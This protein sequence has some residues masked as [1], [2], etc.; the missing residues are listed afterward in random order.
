MLAVGWVNTQIVYDGIVQ[1]LAVALIAV[2]VVLVYRATRIINFAVGNMGVI[3]AALLSLLVV[4]YDVPFWVAL[5]IALL[6]GL[7]FGAVI[8][9]TV[10]RRLRNAPRVVVLVSTIGIAGLAQVIAFKIPQPSDVSAHYPATFGS[11]AWTIG[12]VSVRG[13]DLG[14]LILVPIA[15]VALIWFLDHTT[16]GKTVKAAASNP[17]LARLSSISPK[18]VSTMVWALAAVLST[19][20]IVLFAGE[21][22]TAAGL[23]NLG[24]ET[25]SYALAAAVIAGLR[26]FRIAVIA[27][28]VIGVGQSVLTYNFLATPGITDLLLLIAVFVAVFFAKREGGEESG[29]FAFSPRTRPIPERLRSIW[30]ARNI[31]KGGILLLGA[32]AVILPLV[33]TEP[34]KQQLYTAVL[35][36]AICASSLTVLTGWLGQLSLG[37][38]AFAGLAALFAARLVTD[39]VPFWVAIATT[40]AASGLLALGVGIGSLRVRGLYLAVVTF[41]LALTAQQY[42]YYLPF[43]SGESPDGQNVPFVPGRLFSLNFPGQR[44]YYYVVLF[45]L[46]L[47]V[48]LLSRLRDSGTGRTIKALRDNEV[49][50][51]AYGVRP[52]RLKLKAFALSGA[53][54][55]LGGALLAGAYANVAFTQ[56]FFLV[57]DSLNL[58]AMVVIG[59]MGSVSGAII[60][61]VVVIGIPALAPN[62]ALVGLLSSSLGLLIVLMYFPRGLNQ[63]TSGLRDAILDWADRRVGDRPA[64]ARPTAAGVVSRHRETTTLADS[65][66]VLDVTDLS[67][68]FGGLVAVDRVSL[69]V[70][71]G[72]IVGLIGANGAGKST[73]MNAVGGFV[74]SAGSVRLLG[75]DVADKPP[76]Y[77]ASLGLGRTFQ[78]ATLFPE[79]TVNETLLVATEARANAGMLTSALGLPKT[80]RRSRATRAEVSELVSFLGLDRY[81]ETYISDLS[82]GTRR[83]VELGGL[84][85]LDAKVLCLDE[86]TAGL[87]QRETEAFGPLI[88]AIQ[89]ELSASVLLIE[90]DMPLIMGISERVYCLETGRIIAE[91]T[92]TDMRE[93][94]RVIASYLGTDERAIVRSGDAKTA[95]R[96]T[97]AADGEDRESAPLTR[98]PGVAPHAPAG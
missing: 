28:L 27:S 6:A 23:S 73:L 75:E 4:Q 98:S 8:E 52:A 54:A 91:G 17:W 43:F 92:P 44:N 2:G 63:L 55:G 36:F 79:L 1:G 94:P 77:R 96:D 12:S 26:S 31:D 67:V 5:A 86:P 56:D 74:P 39:G 76:G 90:H 19:L 16:I 51:T 47:V 18:L 41:V 88:C 21:T 97:A 58:V 53:L 30:W 66:P 14:I 89:K 93:D 48:A 59:G 60:G 13:A 34:S 37:Q 81:R 24:P 70:D 15:V 20:S 32:V 61:A 65:G 7:V 35:G 40:V 33:Q 84:L 95:P 45:V 62:N 29:V 68:R 49:A 80:R 64:P 72:E 3:G 85:A 83:I 87:A 50:A 46:A 69:H 42:F 82:T 11:D 78:S 38:M 57:N 71:A 9:M 25:L 22:S 10:I